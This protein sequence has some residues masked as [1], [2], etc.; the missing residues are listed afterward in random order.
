MEK[1]WSAELEASGAIYNLSGG[2]QRRTDVGGSIPIKRR[3]VDNFAVSSLPAI[4]DPNAAGRG[5]SKH[6]S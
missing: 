5:V 2:K 1:K 4:I 3:R 6:T